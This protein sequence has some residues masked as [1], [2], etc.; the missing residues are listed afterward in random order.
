MTEIHVD[1]IIDEVRRMCIEA[2][3]NLP[4]DVCRALEKAVESEGNPT[5]SSVLELLLENADIAR[6]ECIPICQD[7][8]MAVFFVEV[9]QDCRIVGGGLT[10]AINEGV[11][12][13]YQAGYLRKSIVSDPLERLNTNDNTPAVIYYDIVPGEALVIHFS[14]KGFGSENMSQLKMLAPAEGVEGVKSFVVQVVREAGPNP[15]PPVVLGVGIGGTMDKAAVLAK[16]A[17]F[18]P[19]GKRHPDPRIARLEEELLELINDLDI[20]PQGF[21]GRT[22][23]LGVSIETFPT[24]IAGLPVAVNV[25][26]HVTRHLTTR[27]GR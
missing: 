9:G 6:N 1:Q 15:C 14:P 11:M 23:A 16:K 7:T 8:G 17:L 21:G 13:G 18:R 3:V 12:Q 26:C 4:P 2:N 10:D 27:L 22:T 25:S 24:H 20:G 5:A 19:I